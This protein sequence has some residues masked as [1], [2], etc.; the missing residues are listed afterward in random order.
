MSDPGAYQPPVSGPYGRD[1]DS[2]R[3]WTLVVY[4][5]YAVGLFTG[6]MT[7]A[8]IVLAYYKR[9]A[10]TGTIYESH[11]RYAIS[12]FWLSLVAWIVGGVLTLVWIGWLVIGLWMIWYIFRIIKGGLA[13]ANRQPVT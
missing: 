10:A 5:L 8:G 7:L 13:A 11:F 3:T 6:I 2:L 4:A 12:T 1:L 9:G